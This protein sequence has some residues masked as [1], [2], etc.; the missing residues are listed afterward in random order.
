MEQRFFSHRSISGTSNFQ[1]RQVRFSRGKARAAECQAGTALHRFVCFFLL[2]ISPYPLRAETPPCGI[3]IVQTEGPNTDERFVAAPPEHVKAALLKALP[4]LGAKVEKD[5]GL[6]IKA[7]PDM[8]LRQSIQQK[9]K[10]SGVRGKYAG[11]GALGKFTIDLREATQDGVKGSLLHIEFH[12]NGF[13]GRLG[14]EGYAQPLAEETACLT[15]L[16]STNDPASN[17]RGLEV[18]DAGLPHQV[19]LPDNTPLKVLLRDP[20]YS[21]KLEKESLGQNVNFEVAEDVVVDGSILVRRGALATG[22]FT[23]VEKTKKAGRH[24]EIEFAFDS[25]TTVDGQKIPVSAPNEQARGGRHSQA[26]SNA[27][28]VGA[29][30]FL[31]KGSDV[32]IRA[33]TTYDVEVSGEHTVQTG[34]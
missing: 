19:T 30:G 25:V 20:L 18:N 32:F 10:D 15:K 34:H 13:V 7:E 4:A 26:M 8:G 27:A 29:I 1:R 5:E 14:G 2:V 12:K 11:L 33:G 6:H 17:P 28:Q 22:H 3:A 24:A 16:L 23:D 31:A 9:N 21:K